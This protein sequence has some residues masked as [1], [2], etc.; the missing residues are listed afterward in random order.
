MGMTDLGEV[1]LRR[2]KVGCFGLCGGR[3]FLREGPQEMGY[4]SLAGLAGLKG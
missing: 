3:L 4:V 2:R 1:Y